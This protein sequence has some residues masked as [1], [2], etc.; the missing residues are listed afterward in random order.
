MIA[1]FAD[2]I[3][4]RSLPMRFFFAAINAAAAFAYRQNDK[5]S[6]SSNADWVAGALRDEMSV[7]TPLT[8]DKKMTHELQANDARHEYGSTAPRLLATWRK[9]YYAGGDMHCRGA[10]I[11]L[12]TSEK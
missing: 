9:R 2:S 6:R 3:S 5:S 11:G 10:G 7:A 1:R 8:Q 12:K 4:S